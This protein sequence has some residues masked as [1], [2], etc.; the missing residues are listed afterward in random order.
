[1]HIDIQYRCMIWR[2]HVMSIHI[3]YGHVLS[4]HIIQEFPLAIHNQV[5]VGPSLCVHVQPMRPDE[6]QWGPWVAKAT[7]RSWRSCRFP[8]RTR[9][10]S[11]CK[12]CRICPGGTWR[13]GDRW[14]RS[15][16]ANFVSFT[17]RMFQGPFDS[18]MRCLGRWFWNNDNDHGWGDEN[19]FN[20]Q[21]SKLVRLII[22]LITMRGPQ[23]I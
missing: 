21:I 1:M 14:D 18:K 6:A 12:S 11:C 5:G 2:N 15:G 23:D 8:A 20:P 13:N 10:K 19:G 4:L 7:A 3:Y 9:I 16:P 17:L 22:G